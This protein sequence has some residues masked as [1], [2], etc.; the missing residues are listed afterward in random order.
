MHTIQGINYD[1]AAARPPSVTSIIKV[2]HVHT[3][4]VTPLLP[5]EY[6]PMESRS[7]HVYTPSQ[8]TPAFF[9]S[10]NLDRLTA[11]SRLSLLLTL[12]A[13]DFY[14]TRS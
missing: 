8:R 3:R 2:V 13:H 7:R 11:T 10:S 6:R 14:C 9:P 1:N 5:D 4:E 12:K